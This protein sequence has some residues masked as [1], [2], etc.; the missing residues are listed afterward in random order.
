[1]S[2][3]R[4]SISKWRTRLVDPEHAGVARE[5]PA[6]ARADRDRCV[7]ADE[8]AQCRRDRDTIIDGVAAMRQIDRCGTRCH[9]GAQRRGDVLPGWLDVRR[10]GDVHPARRR[11]RRRRGASASVRSAGACSACHCSPCHTPPTV[12]RRRPAAQTLRAS[13][14]GPRRCRDWTGRSHLRRSAAAPPSSA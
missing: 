9:R 14:H 8:A 6:D 1:M 2:N 12:R 10:S 13:R 11:V 4:R 5:A 7:H 3:A